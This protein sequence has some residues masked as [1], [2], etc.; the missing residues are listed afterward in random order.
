[1]IYHLF[2][3]F[4]RRDYVNSQDLELLE[5]LKA[6]EPQKQ[7]DLADRS[8][9]SLGRVN[10]AIRALQ[11]AG[12]ADAE[13]RLTPKAAKMLAARKPA[14]AVILAAGFGLRMI[15]INREV[16][17]AL[18]EVRGEI[19]IERQIRQLKEAGIEDISVVTG[20][21]KER[22]EY[23]IDEFG[24][25]LIVNPDYISA[26]NL[27]S[28]VKAAGK[29]ENC[30]IVPCDLYAEEAI[31]LVLQNLER[32]FRDGQDLE[33]R[34]N[35]AYAALLAGLAFGQPKTAGCHACSYP[36]S[37]DYHLPHGE[38]CA[39]T[40]D[41]FVQIN[42]SPRMEEMLQRAGLPGG[43]AELVSRIRALKAM[44][45]LRTKLGDLGQV[46]VEKLAEDCAVHPL[47]RNNPVK[48]SP[49]ALKT[50]FEAL[51]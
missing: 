4:G 8:G 1:M 48:M 33:A 37:Q 43:S 42:T 6:G 10:K 47:M 32:S 12:Y 50:M 15:P 25:E 19:L 46:D 28:L 49:E 41:S 13:N 2:T 34:S 30:Y 45:G 22:F 18:L 31:R 26:N 21:M 23:L 24:V 51:S 29:L 5:Y 39:F 27:H 36:L 7:R 14:R 17:K 3:N 16:P 40:L 20:F 11:E 35:M 44:A 38:A 9:L